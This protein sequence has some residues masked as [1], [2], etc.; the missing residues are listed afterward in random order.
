MNKKFCACAFILKLSKSCYISVIHYTK[1]G[2]WHTLRD[3]ILLMLLVWFEYIRMLLCWFTRENQVNL[4]Q[5]HYLGH[6][7]QAEKK[8][9]LNSEFYRKSPKSSEDC[10]YYCL[11]QSKPLPEID[12]AK[13]CAETQ[14]TMGNICAT[15]CIM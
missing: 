1:M 2:R 6:L 10:P 7:P 13:L 8:T 12:C 9:Q 5:T 15:V 3:I 11:P 14:R 4:L